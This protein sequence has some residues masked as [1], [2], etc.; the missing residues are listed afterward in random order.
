MLSMTS[1]KDNSLNPFCQSVAFSDVVIMLKRLGVFLGLSG[2]SLARCPS[3]LQQKHLPSLRSLFFLSHLLV[4]CP[5]NF[6]F[7]DFLSVVILALCMMMSP[8]VSSLT[9]CVTFHPLHAR[10]FS[11][12]YYFC[13]LR[14]N[15]STGTGVNRYG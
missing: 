10:N 1:F 9:H 3:F 8:S 7:L 5:L 13:T 11:L 14:V 12:R 6:L 2:H 4:F 15:W